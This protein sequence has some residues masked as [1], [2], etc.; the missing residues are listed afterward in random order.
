MK[1]LKDKVII[2]CLGGL[3]GYTVH[4][5][6]SS[7][8][9]SKVNLS[10]DGEISSIKKNPRTLTSIKTVEDTSTTTAQHIDENYIDP[11]Y[12]KFAAQRKEYENYNNRDGSVNAG[13][14]PFANTIVSSNLREDDYLEQQYAEI[15]ER[16]EDFATEELDWDQY[17]GFQ[18]EE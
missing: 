15:A 10:N 1:N 12:L 14:N 9:P 11:T 4:F 6:R 7:S 5:S 13:A 16:N 17:N 8:Y 2:I 3:L 18:D